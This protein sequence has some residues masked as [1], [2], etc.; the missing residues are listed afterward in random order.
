MG[1]CQAT[2]SLNFSSN[3]SDMTQVFDKQKLSCLAGVDLSR[4]GSIDAPIVDLTQIIN[5][6]PDL[7]TLSSCSG[8]IV[9]LRESSESGVR[10]AGCDWLLVSH[11]HL[12]CDQV[13]STLASRDTSVPGCV[14]IKFEP[15]VLHVQCRDLDMGRSVVTA[16][17]ESGFRNSGLTVSRS[18]K[19]VAAVRSTHGLETPVTD[20]QG[21]DMVSQEYVKLII[22]KANQKL[23]ENIKRRDKFQA[24]LI[25]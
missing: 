13:I 1:I 5:N 19:I 11:D 21:H 17:S 14:V 2:L 4:K 23:T 22:D 15:F 7:F 20:D 25:W 3:I 16:A 18:G 8:R 6:H 9:V 12:G 24:A 10:K